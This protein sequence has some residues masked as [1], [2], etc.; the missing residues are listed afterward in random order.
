MFGDVVVAVKPVLLRLVS[1]WRF[2]VAAGFLVAVVF[3]VCVVV[4]LAVAVVRG[5][6][7]CVVPS[8]FAAVV[9]QGFGDGETR[10]LASEWFVV[11]VAVADAVLWKS[12]AR[13]MVAVDAVHGNTFLSVIV[14]SLF[15]VGGGEAVVHVVAVAQNRLDVPDAAVDGSV[16]DVLDVTVRGLALQVGM[17]VDETVGLGGDVSSIQT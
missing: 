17:E 3:C 8:W 13:G 10:V 14:G 11:E 9:A 12:V 16:G 4:F 7:T 5:F 15:V 2:D 6:L 1:C